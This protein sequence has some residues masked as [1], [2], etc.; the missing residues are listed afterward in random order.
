MQMYRFYFLL[1]LLFASLHAEDEVQGRL[2]ADMQPQAAVGGCVNAVSGS[3]FFSETDISPKG[4]SSLQLVRSYDSG[5]S[6]KGVFGK[7]MSHNFP[8]NLKVKEKKEFIGNTIELGLSLSESSTIP[9]KGRLFSSKI[10]GG[11]I[12]R[13][14][15]EKSGFSCSYNPLN[16]ME[17]HL[18]KVRVESPK[19]GRWDVTLSNGTKKQFQHKKKSDHRLIREEFPNR[20]CNLYGYGSDQFLKVRQRDSA[21]ESLT[22][23]TI[24]GGDTK[25]ACHEGKK[26]C[27]YHFDSRDRLKRVRGKHLLSQDYEYNSSGKM[28]KL[29]KGGEKYL[30][31]NY[32]TSDQHHRGKVKNIKHCSENGS[33]TLYSFSYA[34]DQTIVTCPLRNKQKY[35]YKNHRVKELEDCS[36]HRT[37]KYRYTEMGDLK[38]QQL[39]DTKTET[40]QHL[41][42][43]EYDR[44]GNPLSKRTYGQI[45]GDQEED[46]L[47][48]GSKLRSDQQYQETTF[49]YSEDGFNNLIKEV[50][51]NGTELHYTYYP[52]TSLVASKCTVREGI[53]YLREFCNYNAAG[54]TTEIIQDDG[55]EIDKDN[56]TDVTY[57]IKTVNEYDKLLLVSSSQYYQNLKT[58]EWILAS[59]KENSYDTYGQLIEQKVYDSDDSFAYS[60]LKEYD[61]HGNV[62]SETNA[63]G[64][65]NLYTYDHQDR[66]IYEEQFGT[67]KITRFYYNKSHELIKE[68]EEHENGEILT[69]T[70]TYDRAGNRTSTTDCYGNRTTFVYD[71]SSRLISTIDCEGNT[72]SNIYDIFNH[73]V[74]VTDKNGNTT[75]KSYNVLGKVL[76]LENP[77]GSISRNQYSIDGTLYRKWEVDGSYTEYTYDYLNRVIKEEVFSPNGES[78][79]LSTKGYKGKKLIFEVDA[80]GVKTEYAYDG[81]AR[82]V[83]MARGDQVEEYA[84]DSMGRLYY[85][86]IGDCAEIKEFDLLGRVIEERAENQAGHLLRKKTFTYDRFGNVQVEREF[87]SESEYSETQSF[88][89]SHNLIEASIDPEGNTTTFHYEFQDQFKKVR[90][91]PLGQE[92]HQ[93]FDHNNN[94][95]L[96]E[97]RCFGQVYASQHYTYDPVGNCI[98]HVHDIMVDG[99]KIGEYSVEWEYDEM[100]HVTREIEQGLKITERF[101]SLGRKECEVK[102]SGVALFYEYDFF[103]RVSDLRSSDETIHYRYSYDPIGNLL[104][105]EDL[106]NHTRLEREYDANNNITRELL[107]NGMES[108]YAFDQQGR[109]SKIILP[110]DSVVDYIHNATDLIEVKREDKEHRYQYD[111]AGNVSREITFHGEEINYIR[112]AN[113]RVTSQVSDHFSQHLGFDA[114]GNIVKE[115]EDTYTYDP[116]YQVTSDREH[117]Y[118]YDSLNNRIEKNGSSYA[119]NELQ[120]VTSDGHL[121]YAYDADGNRILKGD[122]HYKYDALNRL[123]ET[124]GVHYQYDSF[125]R[126]MSRNGELFCYYKNYNLGNEKCLRLIGQGTIGIETSEGLFSTICDYRGSVCIVLDQ[127]LS[128]RAEYRY[129]AYG[130]A[131]HTGDIHSPWQFYSQRV[132]D[133]TGLLHFYKRVYD[134]VIGSWLTPDPSGFSDGPNLYAYVHNNPFRFCDPYG[135]SAWEF[136]KGFGTAAAQIGVAC[137][138]RYAVVGLIT[139]AC[140]AAG[141]VASALITSYTVGSTAY[142]VGSFIN[143]NYDSFQE[144][145]DKV[146]GGQFGDLTAMTVDL[147]SNVPMERWGQLSCEA[148]A[149]YTG[150][151]VSNKLNP[152]KSGACPKNSVNCPTSGKGPAKTT[153]VPSSEEVAKAVERAANKAQSAPSTK[154]LSPQFNPTSL[155]FGADLNR[156]LYYCDKYGASNVR[157]LENGSIRYYGDLKL[158]RTS[159]TMIGQRYVHEFNMDIGRSR[160]WFETLDI[161]MNV[162]QVRP[163]FNSNI[164]MHYMFNEYGNFEKK[165]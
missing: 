36:A 148:A 140:P 81:L 121:E 122:V 96:S 23:L 72:T 40:C 29:W 73:P 30:E 39:I 112:D 31:V 118:R 104:V 150:G 126:L 58:D 32:Y 16:R 10:G 71:R 15:Y 50:K 102:P 138:A 107:P 34:K 90:I 93:T 87:T 164:K 61:D 28:I 78:L 111:M 27:V 162:R 69:K 84:Y 91:D 37:W 134:P 158:A 159:G 20:L 120:Q 103:G 38:W 97:T 17:P 117:R 43:F 66:K 135:L 95:I 64:E 70:H 133:K 7:G 98:K 35:T 8:T 99:E 5:N 142:S 157:Y 154:L 105:S 14:F 132:D 52:D 100:G 163:Q 9:Y 53:C 18:G 152:T 41:V 77:D 155:K 4:L 6:H 26:Y 75:K 89:N 165:W 19:K 115:N 110:N 83:S 51:P 21:N 67:G 144:V 45:T 79:A 151:K 22:F 74:A 92:K 109:L 65:L 153:Y 131:K 80:R 47:F 59:R 85:T 2:S 124:D 55:S 106:I 57:R 108:R 42:E 13:D 86:L 125:G 60:L 139:A 156:H 129:S 46:V 136:C 143:D 119:H 82:K 147:L 128:Q 137:M 116:L 33:Q 130:E 141:A 44:L 68:V 56:L 62:L 88:Y 48:W 145:G 76:K 113:Q 101:Y 161:D 94:C 25:Y 24:I 12:T 146:L 1:F 63:L 3:F 114:V 123:I 11:S 54:F 160:G 49:E 127:A 149:M